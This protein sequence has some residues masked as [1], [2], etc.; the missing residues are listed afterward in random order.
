MFIFPYGRCCVDEI[1]VNIDG[2]ETVDDLMTAVST[3]MNEC[4][5]EEEGTL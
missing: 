4:R 3:A 5:R 2:L 1:E